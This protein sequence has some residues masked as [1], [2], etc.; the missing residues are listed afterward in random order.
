MENT[1]SQEVLDV[2][3]EGGEEEE[4][5]EEVKEKVEEAGEEKVEEAEEKVEE[6]EVAEETGR[7]V[8]QTG[9]QRWVRMN[10]CSKLLKIYFRIFRLFCKSVKYFLVLASKTFNVF[11][12]SLSFMTVNKE[13]LGFEVLVWREKQLEDVTTE[14]VMRIFPNFPT[15]YRK[16]TVTQILVQIIYRSVA[17]LKEMIERGR[18][19]K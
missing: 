9:N 14:I 4:E 18:W 1:G 3:E 11:I 5:E 16:K 8:A 2:E 19:R 15:F 12:S 13:S 10:F 6:A 17:A 7:Q